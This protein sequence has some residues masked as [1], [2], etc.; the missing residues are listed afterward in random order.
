MSKIFL[1]TVVLFILFCAGFL[2]PREIITYER[3]SESPVKAKNEAREHKE[4]ESP[5]LNPKLKPV[6][7]CESVGRPDK[8]P[9]HY[10]PSGEVIVGVV[11]GSDIG[12]CQINTEYHGDRAKELGLDLFDK[13]DNITF[14]NLLFEEQG[15]TPWNWSRHC[16]GD[17]VPNP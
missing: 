2:T 10:A 14:A 7:A 13:D 5:T 3:P 15:Y 6:C 12:M 4:T 8:D 9:K 16:W 1:T 17:Y 11:N